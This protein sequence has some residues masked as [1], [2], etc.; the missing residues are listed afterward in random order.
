MIKVFLPT[1]HAQNQIEH[2]EGANQ[3]QGNKVEPG[4]FISYGIINLQD[5]S[6][7]ANVFY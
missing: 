5:N 1:E 7:S 4:P 2:K 3:N 6:G